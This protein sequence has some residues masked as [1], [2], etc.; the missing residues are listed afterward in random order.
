MSVQ[1]RAVLGLSV[2]LILVVVALNPFAWRKGKPSHQPRQAAPVQPPGEVPGWGYR[3]AGDPDRVPGPG[4]WIFLSGSAHLEDV[5]GPTEMSNWER[6]VYKALA[7]P[8]KFP[9]EFASVKLNDF[10]DTLSG[11]TD[12]DVE[13]DRKALDDVGVDQRSQV[14]VPQGPVSARAALEQVLRPLELTWVTWDNVVLVTSP[15]EAEYMFVTKVYDVADLVEDK[16]VETRRGSGTISYD[17]NLVED[18]IVEIR[19]GSGAISYDATF[20]PLTDLITTIV[21]PVAWDSV[22]GPGSIIGF[23]SAGIKAIIVTQTRDVHEEIALLLAGL[24][25]VRANKDPARV[26]EP[27]DKTPEHLRLA[28]DR[29][30]NLD[31]AEKPLDQLVK[32]LSKQAGV[33]F[34]IDRRALD[35][36]GVAT[37]VP[38][39]FKGQDV[40]LRS[41][42]NRTLREFDLTWIFKFESIWITTPEE[43]ET[44]LIARIYDVADFASFRNHEGRVVPDYDQLT[45]SIDSTIQPTTWDSV[46]GPG[47]IVP[48]GEAG[49]HVLIVKQTKEVH[50]E[51]A[52][53]LAGLRQM[54]DEDVRRQE[55]CDPKPLPE[56]PFGDGTHVGDGE[57]GGSG[58]GGFF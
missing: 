56:T 8:V 5:Y 53:C 43:A 7:K 3:W 27:L 40:A 9:N 4:G 55:L 24:R 38:V 22:G 47:T 46:G 21:Q 10:C 30:I 58:G 50:E 54:R 1:L 25:R 15:E 41:L 42:L 16:F 37:D 36:V 45:R 2:V 6:A 48:F 57:R 28:L 49:L 39:T 35:D 20:G 26:V 17:A 13:I 18:K 44:E 29:P 52:Q 11:M 12:V 34:A 23:R 14:V 19:R 33:P 31:V 51:V 32:S